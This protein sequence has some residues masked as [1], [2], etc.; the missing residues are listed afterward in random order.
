MIL[1]DLMGRLD[2]LRNRVGRRGPGRYMAGRP[3][4]LRDWFHLLAGT[5]SGAMTVCGLALPQS[6]TPEH[7]VDLYRTD[8]ISIFPRDR[9]TAFRRVRQA[10]AEKYD[11]APFERLL[12]DLYA[13]YRVS[14]CPASLF[15]TAYDAEQRVPFFFKHRVDRS[16]RVS[17]EHNDYLVR[18]AVRAS[19]AA[20]TFFT[21]LRLVDDDGTSHTLVDGAMVANNPALS[22]YIEARKLYPHVRNVVVVSL[23]T[24]K[25]GRRYT[26]EQ[27]RKWGYVDWISPAHGVPLASMSWSAQS[28]AISHYLDKLPGVTY[29][30]FNP[31]LLPGADEIDNTTERNI[32]YL[33]DTATEF[34]KS[35][36]E[37]LHHVAKRLL[38]RR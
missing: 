12:K 4:V 8:G 16:G 32:M 13:E 27:V 2:F 26:Y 28:T 35:E 17:G 23:G 31:P 22:A 25:T 29:Y 20:P 34:I 5:S 1:K 14:D 7:I 21:P 24:G 3:T 36:S 38:Y 11:A 18:D 30:R 15:L 19:T 37:R 33:Q 9:Y 10:V 6:Y